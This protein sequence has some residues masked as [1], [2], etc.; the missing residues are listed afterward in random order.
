MMRLDVFSTL[1]V[2]RL[3]SQYKS[4]MLIRRGVAEASLLSIMRERNQVIWMHFVSLVYGPGLLDPGCGPGR[5]AYEI[6]GLKFQ[7]SPEITISMLRYVQ[8]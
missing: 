1:P 3:F 4:E 7:L 5:Q 6:A 2:E 8:I